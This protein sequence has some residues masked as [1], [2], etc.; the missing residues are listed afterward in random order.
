[1]RRTAL[2]IS[3]VLCAASAVSCSARRSEPLA[4]PLTISSPAIAE[5]RAVFMAHCHQC[6]PGGE[7]G[8]GP[9]LNNKPLPA[10]A[11]RTQIRRGFGAMPAFHEDEIN[12]VELKALIAYLE[13][14]RRHG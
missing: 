13:A 10:F 4:G 9:A 6:H 5:G 3:L 11:V 12:E 1:M 2:L 14:L 8:L 7:A